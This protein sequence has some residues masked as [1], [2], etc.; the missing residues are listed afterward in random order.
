MPLSVLGADKLRQF[1]ARHI[2]TVVGEHTKLIDIYDSFAR[3]TG[4][5]W[6]AFAVNQKML[7]LDYVREG[8]CWMDV[9]L[10]A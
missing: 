9:A 5:D 4:E 2:F 1:T 6:S 8:D 3:F 10:R 7:Q